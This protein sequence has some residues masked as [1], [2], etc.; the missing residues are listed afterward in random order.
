MDH[1]HRNFPS[2]QDKIWGEGSTT[3]TIAPHFNPEIWE[4]IYQYNPQM[5]LIYIARNPIDRF[6]S[7]YMHLYQRGKTDFTIDEAVDKLPLPVDCGKYATQIEP[8][9]RRFGEKQVLLLRFEDF[10]KSQDEC[11][12]RV[13]HFLNISRNTNAGTPKLHLNKSL[14]ENIT[15]HQYDKL[16]RSRLGTLLKKIIPGRLGKKALIYWAGNRGRLLKL[17]PGLSSKSRENLAAIYLPEIEKLEA[18]T[19]WDLEGWKS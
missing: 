15:P 7:H 1:Y 17:R 5:K 3:Y 11:F 16:A 10:A 2:H 12:G 18:F 4:M 14:E 13:C 19:G 6:V 9:L 8:Y